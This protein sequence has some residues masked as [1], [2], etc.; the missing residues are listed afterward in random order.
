MANLKMKEIKA[1]VPAKDYHLSK[2]FY[3]D[4]GFKIGHDSH[5][6]TYFH[7]DNCSFLLQNFYVKEHASNFMMH[8][9]VED[10]KSWHNK[11]TAL[12]LGENYDAFVGDISIQPW[13]MKDFILSDPS[14]VLWRFGQLA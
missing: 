1:F 4:I 14:K 9:L 10:L 3:Q 7:L 12:K 2:Q 8:I 6:V 5:D 13:G 11:L